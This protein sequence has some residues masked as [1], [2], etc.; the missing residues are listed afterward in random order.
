MVGQRLA[1]SEVWPRRTVS[2]IRVVIMADEPWKW[3]SRR[4]RARRAQ[5]LSSRPSRV[6]LAGL[7][8]SCSRRDYSDE[9]GSP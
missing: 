9:S 1:A 3:R 6:V 5:G 4:W 7:A 8:H 2:A